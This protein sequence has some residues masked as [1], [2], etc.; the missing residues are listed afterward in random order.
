MRRAV[1]LVLLP[2]AWAAA[3]TDRVYPSST[4]IPRTT[5]PPPPPEPMDDA[6]AGVPSDAYAA[7]DVNLRACNGCICSP[8]TSFCFAGGSTRDP[9][10]TEGRDGGDAGDAEAGPPMCPIVDAGVAAIGC[11]AL[12]AA[13]AKDRSCACI[14]AALEPRFRCYLVCEETGGGP[15]VYCPHP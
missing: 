5:T 4:E 10:I 15:L 12:P 11:N 6:A 9:V 3:C 1:L 8:S 2:V 14:L 13:C 7:G